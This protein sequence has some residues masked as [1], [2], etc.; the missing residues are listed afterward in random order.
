MIFGNPQVFRD[1]APPP[2]LR[3]TRSEFPI[4]P[5]LVR[6]P[7]GTLAAVSSN[8]LTLF[9]STGTIISETTLPFGYVRPAAPVGDE[10][11][12][13]HFGGEAEV[14]PVK[15]SLSFGEVLWERPGLDSE[16]RTEC[17]SVALGIAS[18][19]GGCQR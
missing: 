4:T 16:V 7:N 5:Q 13:Q 12:G 9:A 18:P 17:G 6:G 19:G 1:G 15:I 11:L 8:R 3:L 14:T 10:L 2:S